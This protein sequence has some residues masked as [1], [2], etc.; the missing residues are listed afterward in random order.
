MPCAWCWK[1]LAGEVYFFT[2][3]SRSVARV[4]GGW[5]VCVCM[6][7]SWLQ[8]SP[9]GI[10][11]QTIA[12]WQAGCTLYQIQQLKNMCLGRHFQ[13]LLSLQ[14]WVPQLEG[15][16]FYLLLYKTCFTNIIN[17]D[18]VIETIINHIPLQDTVARVLVIFGLKPFI[19][20]ATAKCFPTHSHS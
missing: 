8:V 3:P 19:V 2:G 4:G 5:C 17:H 11:V 20:V 1:T 6:G 12:A 9:A 7:G 13:S 10:T 14:V 15:C 18:F 16:C